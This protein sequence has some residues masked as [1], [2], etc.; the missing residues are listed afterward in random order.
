MAGI[1]GNYPVRSERTRLS[2]PQAHSLTEIRQLCAQESQRF[3]LKQAH[4]PRYCFELLRRAIVQRDETAWAHVYEQY[5][6]LVERWVWRCPSF[7]LTGEEASY[8]VNRAFEKFWLALTPAKFGRFADLKSLLQYLQ[9]CVYSVVTDYMRLK[10]QA[11]QLQAVELDDKDVGVQANRPEDL[12]SRQMR[13]ER[14]W[15]L[16]EERCS[17]E[18]ERLAV[19]GLFLLALKPRQVQAE[20]PEVFGSGREVSQVKENLLAR[21]RRDLAFMSALQDA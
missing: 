19:Y 7:P 21:L 20:F 1:A 11:L 6:A 18:Q 9:M 17:N 15:Q 10:E 12:A 13:R 4:D 2:K 5:H 3:F 14:L 16:V 8:F